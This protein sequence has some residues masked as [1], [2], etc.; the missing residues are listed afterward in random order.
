MWRN[1]KIEHNAVV[2]RWG[3]IQALK[4]PRDEGCEQMI[5]RLDEYESS[6]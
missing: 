2:A 1:L 6:V 3:C 4:F 5:T